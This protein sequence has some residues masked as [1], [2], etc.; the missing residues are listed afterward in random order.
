MLWVRPRGPHGSLNTRSFD[1]RPVVTAINCYPPQH[2]GTGWSVGPNLLV[3]LHGYNLNSYV[4]WPH[5]LVIIQ[6]S[7]CEQPTRL[8][9]IFTI[10]KGQH[11]DRQ[12]VLDYGY[13]GDQYSFLE[14]N[15]HFTQT[16]FFWNYFTSN[17]QLRSSRKFP[18]SRLYPALY[19]ESVPMR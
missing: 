16:E 6:C 8:K 11:K 7:I 18:S 3:Y 14:A 13:S 1:T 2:A 12:Y 9:L 15:M 19:P 5:L 4:T 10:V 17:S